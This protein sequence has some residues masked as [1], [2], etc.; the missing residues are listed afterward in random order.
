MRDNPNPGEIWQH[1]KGTKY[2]VIGVA[3]LYKNEQPYPDYV[4]YS[5]KNL[6]LND[7]RCFV[8]VFDTGSNNCFWLSKLDDGVLHKGHFILSLSDETWE[9]EDKN[10]ET[11]WGRPLNNFMEVLGDGTTHFYHFSRVWQRKNSNL[12]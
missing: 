7:S 2:T 8:R 12:L 6:V 4:V 3:K 5:K 10:D 9:E 1:F 11:I